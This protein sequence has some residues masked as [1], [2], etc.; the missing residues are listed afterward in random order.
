MRVIAGTA[1]GTRL[2]V[3][4]VRDL[5]P[6]TDRARETLFNVISARTAAARVLDLFAGSGALGIE[7]LSRGAESATFVERSS[8]ATA[9]IEYNVARCHLEDRARIVRANWRQGLMRLSNAFDLVLMDPPYDSSHA[10]DC[11]AWLVGNELLAPDALV[12]VEHRRDVPPEVASGWEVVR[13]LRVSES[14]FLLCKCVT[15][16]DAPC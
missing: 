9:A 4:K 11:L 1:R 13:Q 5:R 8:V 14:A 7:A 3:P 2:K 12:V 6:T 15:G 10:A 16:A